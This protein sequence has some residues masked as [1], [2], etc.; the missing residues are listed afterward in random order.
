[1]VWNNKL[2]DP[3]SQEAA[4]ARSR[5]CEQYAPMDGPSADG[6]AKPNTEKIPE[7]VPAE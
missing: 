2:D 3:V 4:A 1:M 7:E 5:R 6:K